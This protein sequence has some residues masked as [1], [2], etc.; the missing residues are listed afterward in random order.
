MLSSNVAWY[1]VGISINAE[2]ENSASFLDW[3]TFFDMISV[4]LT[5]YKRCRKN[6]VSVF[7]PLPFWIMQFPYA[8]LPENYQMLVQE[9]CHQIPSSCP[10]DHLR[11]RQQLLT[12]DSHCNWVETL[13][14][15]NKSSSKY[16]VKIYLA[17]TIASTVFLSCWLSWP[18][19]VSTLLV[20]W[21][22]SHFAIIIRTINYR[23]HIHRW[24]PA[25]LPYL[26][27]RNY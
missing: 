21:L 25:S 10:M 7:C 19:G 18:S 14:Y 23:S 26:A 5:N 13:R 15:A 22:S 6:A 20:T 8:Q 11:L 16:Q 17:L 27:I 4:K 9:Y 3:S 24:K 12:R 2:R 1:W